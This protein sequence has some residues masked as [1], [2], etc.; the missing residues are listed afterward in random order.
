MRKCVQNVYMYV[1][2]VLLCNLAQEFPSGLTKFYLILCMYLC[3]YIRIYIYIYAHRCKREVHV[4]PVCQDQTS[5]LQASPGDPRQRCPPAGWVEDSPHTSSSSQHHL[6][7]MCNTS[8]NHC[9]YHSCI[10]LQLCQI[11]FHRLNT[12]SCLYICIF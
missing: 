2:I 3:A 1:Y 11:V 6:S 8:P 9:Y 10:T 12:L 7:I 4:L 5:S